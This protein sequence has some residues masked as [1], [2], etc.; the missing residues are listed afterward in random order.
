MLFGPA[1]KGI[2][3]ATTTAVALAEHHHRSVPWAFNRK[4]A[5][6]HGEGGNIVGAPLKGRV[7]IVDDVI[8]AG[9]AIRESVEII[10]AAG[11]DSRGRGPGAGSPGTRPG[12]AI[13][14]SGSLGAVRIAMRQ[15]P[16]PGGSHRNLRRRARV[17]QF[18]FLANSSPLC[19]LTSAIGVSARYPPARKLG[20]NS[21][22]AQSH[23]LPGDGALRPV[24]CSGGARAEQEPKARR[25][26]P[27][28]PTSGS[29][30]KA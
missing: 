22:H 20:Q 10:R 6:D 5:K 24:G 1:Y 19:A 21:P 16:D 9:T 30:T 8:T 18:A 26:Q 3:L 13:G 28:R 17:M 4:E 12:H 14:R 25:G 7:V 27:S 11:A 15:H 29:T 2:P 23:P